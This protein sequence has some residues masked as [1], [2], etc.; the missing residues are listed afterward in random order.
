MC[1]FFIFFDFN[2]FQAIQA[3]V[4]Y[5]K[6]VSK[7]F[8]YKLFMFLGLKVYFDKKTK[9]T[10]IINELLKNGP[11]YLIE[12]IIEALNPQKVVDNFMFLVLFYNIFF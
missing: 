4:F 9:K 10:V 5:T 1:F 6:N 3:A 2:Y 11:R 8:K 7:M 12:L